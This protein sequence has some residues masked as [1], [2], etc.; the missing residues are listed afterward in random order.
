MLPAACDQFPENLKGSSANLTRTR[1]STFAG[2]WQTLVE[3][4]ASDARR[5]A[6]A[7]RRPARGK[8]EP[9]DSQR[10]P[11]ES[12][13]G[14]GTDP[15]VSFTAMDHSLNRGPEARSIGMV[16]GFGTPS[17][18]KPRAADPFRVRLPAVQFVMDPACSPMSR[19]L[20]S[21]GRGSQGVAFQADAGSPSRA[22]DAAGLRGTDGRLPGTVCHDLRSGARCH[23][24]VSLDRQCSSASAGALRGEGLLSPAIQH[25]ICERTTA[26]VRWD[27]ASRAW[28]VAPSSLDAQPRSTALAVI[29]T[30]RNG[31]FSR[32]APHHLLGEAHD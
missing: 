4:C 6:E 11:R 15:G 22:A 3:K 32:T 26:L 29:P 1:R 20:V 13:L 5:N 25:C 31:P 16:F 27:R 30:L 28:K 7:H 24:H 21:F 23:A 17:R 12:S 2:R 19:S 14:A 8:F 10:P 18:G 9:A